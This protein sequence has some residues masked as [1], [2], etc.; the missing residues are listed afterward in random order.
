M[1]KVMYTRRTTLATLAA[2][3]SMLAGACG[4]GG[5]EGGA[6]TTQKV[7]TGTLQLWGSYG[8]TERQSLLK[9]LNEFAQQYPGTTVEMQIYTNQDFMTKL[10]AALAGGTGPDFTRFKEYQALD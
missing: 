4:A 10:I 5:G 6:T 7:Q 8:A 1:K 3:A 9:Y 2:G